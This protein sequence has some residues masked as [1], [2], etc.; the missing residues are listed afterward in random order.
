MMPV[1]QHTRHQGG[2][3]RADAE[4]S[5]Q[6]PRSRPEALRMQKKERQ[7]RGR[8]GPIGRFIRASHPPLRTTHEV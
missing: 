3:A 8:L 6:A 1:E 7:M 4:P 5:R 2:D